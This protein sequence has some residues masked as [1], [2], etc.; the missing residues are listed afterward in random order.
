MYLIHR[1]FFLASI[2]LFFSIRNRWGPTSFFHLSDGEALI[3]S[4]TDIKE[5]TYHDMLLCSSVIAFFLLQGYFS[6]YF[7]F[8]PNH[9]RR[10][11]ELWTNVVVV[12]HATSFDSTWFCLLIFLVL[13]FFGGALV[14]QILYEFFGLYFII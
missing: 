13:A 14:M 9:L 10:T 12:Y 6:V 5:D 3:R 4:S 7:W 2:Y 1:N 11:Y 8:S